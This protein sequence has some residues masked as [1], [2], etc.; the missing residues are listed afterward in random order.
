MS[1]LNVLLAFEEFGVL[2][3]VKFL[4]NLFTVFFQTV[5]NVELNILYK[6]LYID[7]YMSIFF[8]LGCCLIDL[9]TLHLLYFIFSYL[10]FLNS[11]KMARQ[12]S[13]KIAQIFMQDWKLYT[14]ISFFSLSDVFIEVLSEK[15]KH[16]F[17]P[18]I[19]SISLLGCYLKMAWYI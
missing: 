6:H 9:Y 17:Y 15:T 14:S 13:T 19:T 2:L 11:M 5:S 8:L 4:S 1:Y 12:N 18:N 7:L 16:I 10:L 3:S